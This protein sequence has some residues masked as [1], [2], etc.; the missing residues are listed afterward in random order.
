MSIGKKKYS[1]KII[2]PID[3]ILN[4]EYN[5]TIAKDMRPATDGPGTIR[6]FPL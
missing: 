1:K 2:K 5:K 6:I 3:N 4:I